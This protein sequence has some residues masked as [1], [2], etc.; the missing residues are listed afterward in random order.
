MTAGT[1][2]ADHHHLA[3]TT[4]VSRFFRSLDVG[5]IDEAW[6]RECS[7]GRRAGADSHR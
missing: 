5:K 6:A 1:V 4:L 7:R 2:R 3:V